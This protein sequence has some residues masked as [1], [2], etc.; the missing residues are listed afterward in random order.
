VPTFGMCAGPDKAA[1]I[2]AAGW[3][4][5]EGS[6]QGLLQG[7]VPDDQWTGEAVIRASALPVPAAN[8]LVP[9][10]LKVTGPTA[11]LESLEEYM[12]AVLSRAGKT[13]VR[14]VVFG[15]GVARAVPEGFDRAAAREQI[16]EFLRMSAPIAGR[17]GV[18][19][20]VEPLNRGECNILNSVQDSME[21]VKAVNHPN[22]QCLVDSYHF[23]LEDEPLENLRD[24]MPWIKHV[25][26][27]DKVGRVA[28]GLSGQSD[29]KPFFN[30]L[31]EGHYD[32]MISFE[33]KEIPDFANEA[34]KVLD[35]V[36]REWSLA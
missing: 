29:Y 15:S 21:Y 36:K 23:W 30:V 11:N 10:S 34:P 20:V 28:P 17:H 7:L 3:A 19:I 4:Y 25:H 27:A 12:T 22:F 31:K 5:V 8:M 2:K 18:T 9:G 32:G 33:G 14:T 26:L 13:G 24:A 1:L 35:Y 16:L 6:V